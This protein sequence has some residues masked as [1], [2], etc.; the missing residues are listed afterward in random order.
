MAGVL[1]DRGK[2]YGVKLTI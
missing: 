1:G 2:G